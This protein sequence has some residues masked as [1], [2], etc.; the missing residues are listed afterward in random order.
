MPDTGVGEDRGEG[1][2]AGVFDAGALRGLVGDEPALMLQILVCFDEVATGVR[3]GLLRAAGAGDA[4]EAGLLG[5]SLKSSARAVGA[6]P[7][8]T[9]CA[10]LEAEAEA[11][12]GDGIGPLVGEV[13]DA[14]DAAL[15]AMEAW[16]D[17]RAAARDREC[18]L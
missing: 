14:L 15:A 5:H 10:R 4:G 11:G 16:C 8:A 1:G 18:A 9:L 7:L 2:Q 13:V 6:F 12:P 3:E 17:A